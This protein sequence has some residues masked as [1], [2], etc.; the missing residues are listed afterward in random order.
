MNRHC[1]SGRENAEV[2]A[3]CLEENRWDRYTKKRWLLTDY[4]VFDEDCFRNLMKYIF[5]DGC[6][7]WQQSEL[8]TLLLTLPYWF[9]DIDAADY[10]LKTLYDQLKTPYLSIQSAAKMSLIGTI[11]KDTGIVISMEPRCLAITCV[12]DGKED[13]K[14]KV[15]LNRYT[16]PDKMEV[17]DDDDDT[18]KD[19]E[20]DDETGDKD[21]DKDENTNKFLPPFNSGYRTN[22]INDERYYTDHP[23]RRRFLN[24]MI[25]KGGVFK[26]PNRKK[27]EADSKRQN[28]IKK[29]LNPQSNGIVFR[30]SQEWK[31]RKEFQNKNYINFEQF[32]KNQ[33][34]N[35][36]TQQMRVC[37]YKYDGY[38]YIT[39]LIEQE[40]AKSDINT[41]DNDDN[42]DNN[43]S[44]IGSDNIDAIKK[45]A[46][47]SPNEI[48]VKNWKEIKNP[49]WHV[50]DLLCNLYNVL[51]NCQL[52]QKK[53]EERKNNSENDN[54]DDETIDIVLVG[55]F[56]RD[57]TKII[58]YFVKQLMEHDKNI[59]S[60][61]NVVCDSLPKHYL[62][63]QKQVENE[64]PLELR[65]NININSK[66]KEKNLRSKVRVPKISH[67]RSGL[68]MGAI[69]HCQ[70][71]EAIINR[72]FKNQRGEPPSTITA[73][74]DKLKLDGNNET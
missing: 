45:A 34:G 14:S 58:K 60:S 19:A 30:N 2:G 59:D 1:R 61:F 22:D 50:M 66:S 57:F 67:Q 74:A 55:P 7:Q 48:P 42:D 13:W 20:A 53:K 17:Y 63:S 26:P 54:E 62:A 72:E 11:D 40:E 3:L 47:T 52:T 33:L 51:V 18:D 16:T 73:I 21:K 23:W 29:I 25:T 46:E 65:K 36:F 15:V 70:S 9:D 37:K 5:A 38:K 71:I 24:R 31:E 43:L 10:I 6:D 12:V 44:R 35:I 28:E 69:K 56:S 64:K 27:V 39:K 41:Q 8:F 4:G 68:L 32:D 49:N